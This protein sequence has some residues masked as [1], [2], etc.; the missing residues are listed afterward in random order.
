M[1]TLLLNMRHVLDEEADEVRAMLE[2]AGIPFYETRP[3]AW[4][5]SAGG[6]FVDDA[7]IAEARRL[8]AEYQ[9]QRSQ[10]VRAEL[11]AQRR[12]GTAE[13]L[14][15]LVRAEPGR[16]ALHVVAALLVIL[17]LVVLPVLLLR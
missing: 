6:I 5:I 11:A 1:S 9:A 17:M 14:A 2:A 13:T 3:S 8:M 16:V 12:A 10:R 15:G 4:G 7:A